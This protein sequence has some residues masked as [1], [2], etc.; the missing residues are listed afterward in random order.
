MATFTLEDWNKKG[1]ELYG[2]DTTK[3]E[4]RCPNCKKIQSYHTLK[5]QMRQGIASQRYGILK[6]GDNVNI[7]QACYSPECNW[8]ANG[9]F[10]SG[11]LIVI[12]KDK[13]FIP[14]LLENCTYVFPFANLTD[15]EMEQM[16]NPELKKYE[17]AV[18]DESIIR[19]RL[20]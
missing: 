17:R 4:F 10:C 20:E 8:V 2:E 14:N 19:K 12:E 7:E 6:K 5:E 3:W 15:E 1:K 13:P 18:P 11:F 16:N 9:L